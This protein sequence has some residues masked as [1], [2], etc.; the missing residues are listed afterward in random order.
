MHV[1]RV[2]LTLGLV[3]LLAGATLPVCAQTIA[4][5]A[6]VLD[7]EMLRVRDTQVRLFGV[8]APQG[9]QVCEGTDDNRWRCGQRAAMAL[10]DILD[11]S[12]VSCL[13]MKRDGFGRVVAVC[14]IAGIDLGLWLV[15]NGLALEWA[16]YSNARYHQAAEEARA[17]RRGIWSGSDRDAGPYRS[18]L[19]SGRSAFACLRGP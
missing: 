18:C 14:T 12:I 13:E 7:G 16:A 10:E 1:L 15:R 6:T 11:E 3:A 19:R 17:Q 8:D 9:D 4:G 2:V 5:R